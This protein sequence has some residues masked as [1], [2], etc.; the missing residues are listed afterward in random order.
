[1]QGSEFRA[2]SGVQRSRNVYIDTPKTV[3]ELKISYSN[4]EIW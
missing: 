2:M 3:K 1:M 4:M